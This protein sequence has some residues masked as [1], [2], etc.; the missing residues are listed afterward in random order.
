ML[1][2]FE[3]LI[4]SN[5]GLRSMLMKFS[6]L[7]LFA[8]IFFSFSTFQTRNCSCHD[9]ITH[10]LL[11]YSYDCYFLCDGNSW[12]PILE[13]WVYEVTSSYLTFFS[14]FFFLQFTWLAISWFDPFQNTSREIFLQKS[15][16]NTYAVL[17][18]DLTPWFHFLLVCP[19]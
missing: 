14:F 15:K 18:A 10:L 2:Y 12:R 11:S 19:H 1:F 16:I 17:K 3:V 7:F 8:Y 6:L 5:F 4:N 13:I 9:N